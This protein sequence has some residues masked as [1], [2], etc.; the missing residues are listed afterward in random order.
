MSS[1]EFALKRS[2]IFVSGCKGNYLGGRYIP[3]GEKYGRVKRV[4]LNGY[5][6]L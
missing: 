6:L 4:F 1:T 5:I 2:F 3:F